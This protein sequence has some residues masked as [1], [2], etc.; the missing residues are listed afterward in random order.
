MELICVASVDNPTTPNAAKSEETGR[1]ANLPA[2][3]ANLDWDF[4]DSSVPTSALSAIPQ[5]ITTDCVPEASKNLLDDFLV[6]IM[7]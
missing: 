1:D 7:K 6:P 3:S 5:S 4:L 2:I